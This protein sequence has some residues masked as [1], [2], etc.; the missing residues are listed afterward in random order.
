MRPQ[1]RPDRRLADRLL[2]KESLDTPVR[3]PRWQALRV[4][5]AFDPELETA[6]SRDHVSQMEPIRRTATALVLVIWGAFIFVDLYFASHSP[7]YREIS[8]WLIA[9]RV[10][11]F[12]MILGCAYH[13][14]TDPRVNEVVGYADRVLLITTS[15]TYCAICLIAVLVPAPFDQLYFYNAMIVVIVGSFVLYSLRSREAGILACVHT[16]LSVATVVWCHYGKTASLVMEEARLVPI[17]TVMKMITTIL[18]CYASSLLLEA[19]ARRIFLGKH[20]LTR[21]SHAMF[22]H[23]KEMEELNC[24]LERSSQEAQA[25]LQAVIELKEKLQRE[26]ERRIRDKS[27]FIASAV[28]DL[29][30]PV[31]AVMTALYPVSHALDQGDRKA[32]DELLELSKQ[33]VSTLNDQLQAILD[34]SRLESGIVRPNLEIVDIRQETAA[35]FESWESPSAEQRVRLEL[36]LPEPEQRAIARTDTSFFRRIVSNLISNGIKYSASNRPGGAFV[37][38]KLQLLPERLS[39]QVIDNGVGIEQTM[40]DSGQIFAPFFQANNTRSQGSKGVGLGLT[41]VN[42]LTSLLPDHGL[43]VHSRLGEGS[44]FTLEMPRTEADLPDIDPERVQSMDSSGLA[45]RYIILLEDDDLVRQATAHL[46]NIIGIH[47]DA[48]ESFEGFAHALVTLE[49][50]PDV[51]LSD[52]R[53]PNGRSAIDVLEALKELGGNVPLVVFSG[54]AMDLS[55]LP[56]LENVPVLRKP[57]AVEVL[58]RTL[59][60]VAPPA[61]SAPD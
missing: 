28:H 16:V 17:T 7:E 43:R 35:I 38:V 40:I 5:Q 44:T 26:T 2:D 61:E 12:F 52:F 47:C 60:E 20:M 55:S 18:I 8:P 37:R 50:T 54:E 11:T 57:L 42:A 15:L 1:R 23:G 31:Q 24:E 49:R 22:L 30:Q 41:I 29:R 53:L 59:R 36:E 51:V 9:I 6:Y 33:A 14:F 58:V 39:V 21:Q 48:Y 19:Y 25:R 34:L 46:L 45:G 4:P 27:H 3:M 56:G 13:F 32:V 10:L